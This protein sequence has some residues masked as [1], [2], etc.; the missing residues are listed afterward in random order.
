[1]ETISVLGFVFSVM[2]IMVAVIVL[3]KALEDKK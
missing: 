2:I 3:K 1:M